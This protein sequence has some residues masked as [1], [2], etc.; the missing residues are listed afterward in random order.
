MSLGTQGA[1]MSLGTQ[2]S[3]A[4]E[5]RHWGGGGGEAGAGQISPGVTTLAVRAMPLNL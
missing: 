4:A 1:A 2:G 3:V 5:R